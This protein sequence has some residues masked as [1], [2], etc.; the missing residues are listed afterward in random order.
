M[1]MTSSRSNVTK[2]SSQKMQ[3]LTIHPN[4]NQLAPSNQGDAAQVTEH[5]PA[6]QYTRRN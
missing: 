5:V 3:T 2:L 6:K 1:T 4:G